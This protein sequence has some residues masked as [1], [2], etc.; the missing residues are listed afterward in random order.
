MPKTKR[1][2][3]TSTLARKAAPQLKRAST[4]TKSDSASRRQAGRRL[5][6]NVALKIWASL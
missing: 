6:E 2:T 4:M 5:F 1:L 3:P